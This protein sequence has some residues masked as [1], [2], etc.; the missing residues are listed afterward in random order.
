MARFTPED[1]GRVKPADTIIPPGKYKAELEAIEPV[2]TSRG[3]ALKYR[4]RIEGDNE[5]NGKTITGL[6]P[7]SVRI[8]SKNCEWVEALLG[9]QLE[10]DEQ[11]NW[12]GLIGSRAIILI[13]HRKDGRMIFAN[14]VAVYDINTPDSIEAACKT[15]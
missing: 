2:T 7:A 1:L 3:D 12:R 15:G 4:F 8:G 6:V 14:V 13:A 9:R 5:F 11:I 10:P